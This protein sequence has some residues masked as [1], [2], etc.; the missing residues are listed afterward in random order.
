MSCDTDIVIQGGLWEETYDIAC[1][2]SELDF[3]NDV[4]ISTWDKELEKISKYPQ[5]PNVRWVINTFPENPG[6]SYSDG[7]PGNINLAILSSKFG[8][9]ETTSPIVVKI[10]SDM[11][12]SRDSMYTL[13]RFFN[14]FSD[15]PS[16][17]YTDSSGPRS[18]IFA[19]GVNSAWPYCPHDQVFWGYREDIVDLFDLPLAAADHPMAVDVPVFRPE[20]YL[21]GYYYARFNDLVGEHLNDPKTYLIDGASKFNEAIDLSKKF[22]HKIFKPFPKIDMNWVKYNSGFMYDMYEAQGAIYY[23]N[24]W[25]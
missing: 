8:V 23:D 1:E 24:E 11:H 10:R 7:R 14:K 21:G 3:V 9:Q 12:I 17:G 18:Q 5:N 13:D 15:T 6:P 2:Y 22:D 20:I 19:L 4:I 25:E 16:I